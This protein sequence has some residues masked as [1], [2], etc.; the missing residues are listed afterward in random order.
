MASKTVEVIHGKRYR[1][2][3]RQ[4]AESLFSLGAKFHIYRNGEYWK[5]TYNSLARA[6][7]VAREAG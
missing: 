7:D 4:E 6:V 1:Y 2:E 5:G 3:I